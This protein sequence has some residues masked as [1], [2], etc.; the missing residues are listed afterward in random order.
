VPFFIAGLGIVRE[1]CDESVDCGQ[2]I[3]LGFWIANLRFQAKDELGKK[4]WYEQVHVSRCVSLHHPVEGYR[5]RVL[6]I[7]LHLAHPAGCGAWPPCS[8]NSL[9]S[10]LVVG[11]RV[12]LL[13]DDVHFNNE[14]RGM[15]DGHEAGRD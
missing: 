1:C 8:E 5:S 9:N 14:T 6:M 15:V 12:F 7:R 11:N 4:K 13:L 2:P 10:M 3:C